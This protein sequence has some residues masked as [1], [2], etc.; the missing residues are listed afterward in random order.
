M[1]GDKRV[2]LGRISGSYGI[3]GWVR[4]FSFTDPREKILEYGPWILGTGDTQQPGVV[5]AG[6][7]HG[8]SVIAALEGI[9]DRDAAKA[10][11]D[12]DIFVDRESMPQPDAGTWYWVDLEGMTVETTEGEGLGNVD[13]FI[14]T[15]ARD[16][17]VVVAENRR[18]L[19]P[20]ARPEIVVDV[21]TERGV[22]TVD[23]HIDD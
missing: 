8:K 5:V 19:I 11:V 1:A 22:I 6:R 15:G 23:W 12:M 3:K 16:V 13:S 2:R 7:R 17:M 4:V 10:L 18:R 14:E 20:F 21:D 9:E